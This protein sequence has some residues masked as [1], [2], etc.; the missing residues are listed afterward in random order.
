[1]TQAIKD[2]D[3]EK[4]AV[5]CA[6]L[7]IEWTFIP[8]YS[9][10]MGEPGRGSL[11]PL[12]DV[13]DSEALTP[14]HF[15]IV[16]SLNSEEKIKAQIPPG[17]FDYRDLILTKQW[18]YGQRLTDCFWKR[19]VREYL[20]VLNRQDKWFRSTKPIQVGDVVI[21][22]DDN[23]IRNQWERA[24]VVDVHPGTDGII[25]VV[26]VKT[27]RGSI[28]RRPVHKLCILDLNND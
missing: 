16:N 24:R 4:I 10:H 26:T 5:K 12:K 20:P 27:A 6:K 14:M 3:Q 21:I 11:G 25:R 19:W 17:K 22:A 8:P 9:P 13:A 2:L 28:Y 1:M 7:E 18:R 15:L 23:A